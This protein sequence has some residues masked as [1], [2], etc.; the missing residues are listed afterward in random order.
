MITI[1]DYGMGNLGSVSKAFKRIGTSSIITSDVTEIS[2]AKRII[3]PCVG[4]FKKGI[5]NLKSSGI[6]AVVIEKAKQGFPIMGI[7]LGMEQR[8]D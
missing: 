6:Y 2:K 5:S 1:I 4:H 7:C 8:R 3:L